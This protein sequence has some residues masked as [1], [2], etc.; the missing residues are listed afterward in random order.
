MLDASPMSW[1]SRQ[2]STVNLQERLSE[3]LDAVRTIVV[4]TP[5]L[6]PTVQVI[7]RW[8]YTWTS[9][10]DVASDQNILPAWMNIDIGQRQA[11]ALPC[12]S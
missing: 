2:T 11:L 10:G 12:S 5:D 3:V 7:S 4:A 6:T 9:R 1:W 8:N